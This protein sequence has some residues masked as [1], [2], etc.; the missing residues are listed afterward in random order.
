MLF[1]CFLGVLWEEQGRPGV[2]C[3]EPPGMGMNGV[4]PRLPRNSDDI[5]GVEI[6]LVTSGGCVCA[7]RTI[8]LMNKN[9]QTAIITRTGETAHTPPP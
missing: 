7:H 2:G 1:L 4:S 8:L 9:Y 6:P 5:R 3:V